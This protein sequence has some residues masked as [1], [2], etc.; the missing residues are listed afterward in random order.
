MFKTNFSN[1]TLILLIIF[2]IQNVSAQK[3]PTQEE[4]KKK[5]TAIQYS[6]TQEDDTEPPYKNEYW[7]N[8]VEG[9]YVDIVSG[10]ALF[11][12]KD[13]YDSGTG[14][15]SFSKPLLAENITEKKDRKLFVTRT[16]VRSKKANS[17]LGHVFSDGPP[18]TGLRYC[19]NSAAM[20][21]I[22]KDKLEA[23][24]Y[25]QFLNQFSANG[26]PVGSTAFKDVV[27]KSKIRTAVLAAGCFWCIQ[28][29]YD[30]LKNKGVISTLVGYSG[31]FTENP[32][33]E[34]TSNEKTG[35]R[36]VIE[37]TYDS[38]KISFKD[39]LNVFWKNI[40]PFDSKGQFCDKGEQYT[41]AVFYSDESEKKDFEDSLKEL[42]KQ[43]F[44]TSQVVT[45]ILPLKKFYKGE[46]YHQE[47]YIK[48]PIRYKYYRYNCGRDKRLKEIW[49]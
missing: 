29:P 15:P 12:S 38:T 7:D 17:H 33:Y 21:F 9:I 31:G 43:G 18:P 36:E 32:T 14:W 35:H 45:P 1:S 6:V 5:L 26:A 34:Q 39:L 19:M 22:P 3:I 4:L 28:P 13:K 23:E 49:K 40:D 41:S 44:K 10:E 25:G 8:K 24:G 11:S 20:R 27:S 42:E 48:N 2:S 16:E 30:A 37:I 47:Y 46:D